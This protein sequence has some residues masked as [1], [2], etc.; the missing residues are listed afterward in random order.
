MEEAAQVDAL[1]RL[2]GE[3]QEEVIAGLAQLRDGDVRGRVDDPGAVVLE[4][5]VEHGGRDAVGDLEFTP[6]TKFRR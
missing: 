5:G 1:D 3:R 2:R 6:G 4:D